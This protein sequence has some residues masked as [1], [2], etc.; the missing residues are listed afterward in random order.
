MKLA[1][2]AHENG[3]QHDLFA[4]KLT[5]LSLKAGVVHPLL[6]ILSTIQM[7]KM[8]KKVVEENKR[9]SFQQKRKQTELRISAKV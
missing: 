9:R 6:K 7:Q 4:Q 1:Q 3:A 5:Y 8:K 2:R